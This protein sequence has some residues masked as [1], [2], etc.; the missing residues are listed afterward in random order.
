MSQ[1]LFE[2][3]KLALDGNLLCGEPMAR[4]TTWRVGGPA[5][6]F[7]APAGRPQL[8]EA[9]RLLAAAGVPWQVVGAG[10]NLLVRDGGIRGAVIH[11][12]RFRELSF[13][14]AG[15]VVAG[16]GLPLMTL[17]RQSAERGLAGL[18]GLAGIPGTVG[19][20]VAMNAGAGG[21]QLSDVVREVVLAGP[22]GEETWEAGKLQFGYRHSVVPSD[23]VVVEARMQFRPAAPAALAEEIRSRLAHRGQAHR[24][25]GPNAGSV[26]KNPPGHQA[27]KL[28]D[29][30]GLR[31]AREGGAQV[32]ERH[33]NFIVNTGGATAGD[34]VRLMA[35]IQTEVKS[36]TGIE[37]EPEVKIL[38]E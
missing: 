22:R 25:G 32:A 36:Q 11:L 34:I 17:I 4:H 18:E 24:V 12:G 23:R 14:Q 33:T 10:S 8:L 15:E 28:I 3:L 26:F 1:T 9:L 16:G 37:L 5:D 29:Q 19:G 7:L 27:W 21:Q 6:L 2:S 30:A 31:G 13:G 20:G 38:G 35:R